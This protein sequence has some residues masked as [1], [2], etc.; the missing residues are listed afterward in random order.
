MKQTGR[1]VFVVMDVNHPVRYRRAPIFCSR[2]AGD[3]YPTG[4]GTLQKM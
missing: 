4:H 2:K 1:L 3:A